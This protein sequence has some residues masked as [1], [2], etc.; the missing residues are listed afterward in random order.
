M[1]SHEDVDEQERTDE[2]SLGLDGRHNE[3]HYPL[4]KNQSLT[5]LTKRHDL[6]NWQIK[7]SMSRTI[8]NYRSS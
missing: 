1:K 2:E 8:A 7:G 6:N 3:S 5:G 4:M